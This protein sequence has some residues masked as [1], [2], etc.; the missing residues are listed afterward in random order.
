[1]FIVELS[2]TKYWVCEIFDGYLVD[3]FIVF[4]FRSDVGIC[5]FSRSSMR[6]V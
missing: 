4:L 6:L 2:L 1:M 5:R 3:D